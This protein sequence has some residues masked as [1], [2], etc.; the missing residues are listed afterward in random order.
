M[1]SYKLE[2]NHGIILSKASLGLDVSGPV[3]SHVFVSHAHADHLPRDRKMS[4]IATPATAALMRQRGFRGE[5][6]ELPFGET[7]DLERCSITLY[8]AGHI[9][10]SAMA[11]IDTEEGHVLYTGDYK[12]PP[13]PATEGFD[14]PETTNYFITE[15]TFP[16]PIYKWKPHEVLF[17]DIC[18]FAADSINDEAIPIFLCY[19]LG[20][21]QEVMYA[22]KD[23]GLSVQIHGAGYELCKIYES[24]GIPLG[25]YEKYDRDTLKTGKVL[26][27]PSSS[28]EQPMV[29]NIRRKRVAYVSGWATHEARR[30]QL[31]VDKLIP[32]S[33][34]IDFFE[35]IKLCRK[36][37]PD[38][39]YITHTPN[40]AVV[41]HYLANEGIAAMPL[42]LEVRD[43]S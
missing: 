17:S 5:V 36:L 37:T 38:M 2:K 22:L 42:N 19:N 3:A 43:D 21:A 20:K 6:M 33:D 18:A 16:L 26:I 30:T 15:A 25:T 31:T 8:P 10:G 7:L 11:G 41:E 34:H 40:P 23:S 9:L 39:V 24:F 28:L 27:T 14:V 13:S 1:L 29:R 12:N 4:V 32:L 35:L